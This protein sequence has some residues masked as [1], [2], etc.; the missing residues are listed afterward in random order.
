MSFHRKS[1]VRCGWLTLTTRTE[2]STKNSRAGFE[3]GLRENNQ[4]D[5]GADL[6]TYR[7][8]IERNSIGKGKA[9]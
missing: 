2:V 9:E 3:I 4:N 8:A 6:S 7:T 1:G 5:F